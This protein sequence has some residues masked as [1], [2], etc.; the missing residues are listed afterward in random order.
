MVT[1]IASFILLGKSSS[2]LDKTTLC[3]YDIDLYRTGN[4][5]AKRSFLGEKERVNRRAVQE[6]NID[7]VANELNDGEKERV[8]S[9]AHKHHE[10]A[11][12]FI[13]YYYC[14]L[15]FKFYTYV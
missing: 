1:L 10:L 2:K 12:P 14:L 3:L 9:L 11:S 7:C 15:I 13:L 4:A 8:N 6:N 5:F